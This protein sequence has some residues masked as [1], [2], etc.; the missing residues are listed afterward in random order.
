M[1]CLKCNG[2]RCPFCLQTGKLLFEIGE[3]VVWDNQDGSVAPMSVKEH[4]YRQHVGKVYRVNVLMAYPD[5]SDRY[6]V[7]I[8]VV[9]KTAGGTTI[10]GNL[11]FDTNL[12]RVTADDRTES[13]TQP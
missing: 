1:K 2:A 10:G 8:D 9:M 4:A 6:Y 7:G 13:E 3:E 11:V 12:R 5:E